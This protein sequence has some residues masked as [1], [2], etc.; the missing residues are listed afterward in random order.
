[1][2]TIYLVRH[3]EYENPDYLFPGR[4][5]GFPLSARGREQV[6][7]LADYFVKKPIAALF[8]SPLLRTMQSAEIISRTIHVPI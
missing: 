2:T 3:G 6:C 7:K 8:S 5:S 4:S 1:M